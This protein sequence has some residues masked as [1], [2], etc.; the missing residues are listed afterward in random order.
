MSL[1][2][3][4]VAAAVVIVVVDDE[5]ETCSSLTFRNRASYI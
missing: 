5:V 4:A 3:I 1:I 2:H